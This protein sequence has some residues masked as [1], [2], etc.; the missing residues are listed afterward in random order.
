VDAPGPG[1]TDVRLDAYPDGGMARLRLWG[2]LTSEG[3]SGLGRRWFDALPDPQALAVLAAAGLTG[4]DADAVVAA[5]P[6]QGALPPAIAAV[7]DGPPA[8]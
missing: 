7:V 1:V 5:R 3:R 2:P 4:A 8:P 6:V